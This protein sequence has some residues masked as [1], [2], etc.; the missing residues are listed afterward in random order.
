MKYFS[1]SFS[2]LSALGFSSV[3]FSSVGGLGAIDSG[4][5]GGK[6]GGGWRREMKGME[7]VC[8]EDN[9]C[10]LSVCMYRYGFYM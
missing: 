7:G 1:T 10:A 9:V 5:G 3:Q 8:L 6:S 2:G 4:L